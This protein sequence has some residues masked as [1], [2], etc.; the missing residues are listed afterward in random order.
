[1]SFS[2]GVCWPCL[3]CARG[4]QQDAARGACCAV[5]KPLRA[6]AAH[7]VP[8]CTCAAVP[9]ML[10]APKAPRSAHVQLA[11]MTLS[12]SSHVVW[13]PF[14]AMHASWWCRNTPQRAFPGK[15]VSA[16]SPGRGAGCQVH[17]RHVLSSGLLSVSSPAVVIDCLVIALLPTEAQQVC[18]EP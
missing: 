3:C 14:C 4:W 1:M 8:G 15:R 17:S 10:H 7:L 12:G 2:C 5:V 9:E 6:A 16:V 11:V 18:L 13:R